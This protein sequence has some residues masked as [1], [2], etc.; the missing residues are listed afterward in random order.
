MSNKVSHII[1]IHITN[2]ISHKIYMFLTIS[3]H[4]KTYQTIFQEHIT[5]TLFHGK[6]TFIMIKALLMEDNITHTWL[7]NQKS[8]TWGKSFKCTIKMMNLTNICTRLYIFSLPLVAPI[9]SFQ[10]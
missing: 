8:I 4:L 6:H 7:K 5:K 1:S 3:T 9:F 2:T 10:T